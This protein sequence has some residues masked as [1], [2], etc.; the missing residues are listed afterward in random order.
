[1][2]AARS[3]SR[4]SAPAPVTLVRGDSDVLVSREVAR[5]KAQIFDHAPDAEAEELSAASAES[6]DLAAHTSPSLFSPQKVLIIWNLAQMSEAFEK[7]F[8]V[9]L[10]KPPE[11]VWVIAIHE[12]GNRGQGLIRAVKAHNYPEVKLDAPKR[13]HDKVALV[14]QEVRANR[15][16]IDPAAA[17]DL[18]SALGD[19]LAELLAAASQLTYDSGGTITRDAVHQFYRGRV[20][21]KPWDVAQAAGEREFV[22]SV[23]LL[24]Q[25]YSARVSPVVIVAALA[26][27]FRLLLK[28]KSPLVSASELGPSWMADK[29][30]RRGRHWGEESLGRALRYIADADAAVKGE[31]RTPE[32]AVELC[33]MKISRLD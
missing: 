2:E 9:Y 13:L 4:A 15:G 24:R 5:I 33:I 31:S 29:A 8:R 10:E 6:G 20:E 12:G 19:D 1:M 11:D 27:E 26:S 3:T 30:R 16:T 22:R 23:L 18:V 14:T 17:Q 28:L 21:T 7:D 32:S 25:A